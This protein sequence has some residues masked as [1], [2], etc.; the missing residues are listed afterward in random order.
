[1]FGSKQQYEEYIAKDNDDQ[2]MEYEKI[3][4]DDSWAMEKI[5]KRLGLSTGTELQSLDKKARDKALKELINVGLSMRQIERLT[6]I[7]RG[8]VKKATA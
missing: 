3:K 5:R 8:V 4:R 2:C 7:S 6:G 1:M